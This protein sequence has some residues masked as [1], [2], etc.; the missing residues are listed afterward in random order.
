MALNL[1]N[2]KCKCGKESRHGVYDEEPNENV[3]LGEFC[4]ECFVR[5]FE[6]T[7]QKETAERFKAHFEKLNNIVVEPHKQRPTTR[8]K[9]LA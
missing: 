3:C 2:K 9:E 6:D 5:F 1:G 8:A 4:D 7:G